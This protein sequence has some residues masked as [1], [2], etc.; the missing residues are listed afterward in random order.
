MQ[1]QK[2]VSRTTVMDCHQSIQLSIYLPPS[3]F[4]CPT[5]SSGEA[6][7]GIATAGIPAVMASLHAVAARPHYAV[8]SVL[9]VLAFLLLLLLFLLLFAFLLLR[10]V[11][12][13]SLLLLVV[14]VPA[15]ACVPAIAV[16]PAV[17]GVSGVPDAYTVAGLPH[18]ASVPGVFDSSSETA[19]DIATAGIPEI[20]NVPAVMASLLLLHGF[21]ILFQAFCCVGTLV[22]ALILAVVCVPAVACGHAVILAVAC[23][24]RPCSCLLYFC[25]LL[26]CY[27]CRS[28]CCSYVHVKKMAFPK[29]KLY[30]WTTACI[31]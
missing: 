12:L 19:V 8:A 29:N 24:W 21:T 22:V 2:G 6:A 7:L 11:I 14:G 13:S 23:C 31:L 3:L 20:S 5:D 16:V 1:S 9:L 26:A 25:C 27:C 18:I 10:A 15:V 17:V 30:L 4:D 28:S